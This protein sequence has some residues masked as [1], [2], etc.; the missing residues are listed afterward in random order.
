[1]KFTSLTT[2]I[3]SV[4]AM[5]GVAIASDNLVITPK[6]LPCNGADSA[7]CS[8]GIKGF[9]NGNDF[10]YYCSPTNKITYYEACSCKH[11]CKVLSGGA[12]FSCPEA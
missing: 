1:M 5:A 9:N 12:D 7:G 8:T 4:A 2:T 6:N 10:G 3:I 11:C